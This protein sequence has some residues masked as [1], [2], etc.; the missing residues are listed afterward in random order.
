MLEVNFMSPSLKWE[1]HPDQSCGSSRACVLGQVTVIPVPG[2][3][4]G[5][6][7]KA[8]HATG[9]IAILMVLD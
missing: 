2:T 7:A 8:L 4:L 6:G 9:K 3:V 5:A 1:R